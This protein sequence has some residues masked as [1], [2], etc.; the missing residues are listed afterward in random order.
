MLNNNEILNNPKIYIFCFSFKKDKDI[1]AIKKE[2]KT[3]YQTY[4]LVNE[5]YDFKFISLEDCIKDN[6]EE[7]DNQFDVYYWGINFN[8]LLRKE[9][10]DIIHVFADSLDG[11]Y[12][13]ERN[14]PNFPITT[15][16]TITGMIGFHKYDEGYLIHLRH[17]VDVGNLYLFVESITV[18]QEFEKIGLQT[19]LMLPRVKKSAIKSNQ[20][21]SK[22]NNFTIGFA[23]SPLSKDIW[24]DRGIYLLL[25]VAQQLTNYKFKVAWRYEGYDEL[26]SLCEKNE[27]NNIEIHNGHLDMAEFYNNI[28]VMLAPY[29]SQSNNHSCPLSIVESVLIGIPALVTEYVGLKDIVA[30]YQLGVI[31]QS[32]SEDLI[33]KLE[34]LKHNYDFYKM[35]VV[36]HGEELFDIENLNKSYMGIYDQLAY[37][38]SSPTLKDWQKELD[39]NN[40]FLVMDRNGMTSY[41]N[42]SFI[43][44]NYDESRFSDF[45]MRTYDKLERK[46]VDIFIKRF[47]PKQIGENEILD[48]ASGDGRILRGLLEFGKVTAVENSSYMIAISVSKL[49]DT[50]CFIKDNFFEFS[51]DKRF[52]IITVFRF[53]RHFNIIDRGTLYKKIYGLLKDDGICIVDFPNTQAETQLRT[54]LKWGSFNVYDVFW[55]KFEILS[56]LNTYGFEVLDEIPVGEYLNI[57]RVCDELPLSRIVCFRKKRVVDKV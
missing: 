36:A 40:M 19:H 9:K 55:H 35:N 32:N 33:T 26:I 20:K 2:A 28:D 15:L 10:P 16:Y 48:I 5:D 31:S 56:E 57:G 44:E 12:L 3:Y 38:T 51:T 47:S 11:Y 17:A 41:Y 7:Y 34:E 29:T 37:Q 13:F 14:Y 45:P 30:H 50:V 8:E 43:A 25:S 53:I 23:S 24:E 21:Q 49:S 54:S 46:A 18:K 1:E 52:D 6:V 22:R 4:K 39:D 27:I 42:D